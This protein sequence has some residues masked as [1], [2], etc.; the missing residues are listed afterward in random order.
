MSFLIDVL[1]MV[2]KVSNIVISQEDLFEVKPT[3]IEVN[4]GKPIETKLPPK[5]I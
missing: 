2:D 3:N 5:T 1:P 4:K